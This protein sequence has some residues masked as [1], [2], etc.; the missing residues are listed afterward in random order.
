MYG[1]GGLGI[2]AGFVLYV[3]PPRA[4]SYLSPMFV[5]VC[6]NFVPFISQVVS[7]LI[8]VQTFPGIWTTYGGA[9]L[10]VGCTL[11]AMDYEDQ[12]EL[13]KIPLVGNTE[14]D[15]SFEVSQI[16]EEAHK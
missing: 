16:K 3:C 15:D 1:I 4:K 14:S 9:C 6:F 2:M 13:A 7:Y 5:N 8:G 10:F 11:L 12:V